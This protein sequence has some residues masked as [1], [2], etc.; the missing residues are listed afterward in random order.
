[1]EYTYNNFFKSLLCYVVYSVRRAD[2]RQGTADWPS[3]VWSRVRI[4]STVALEIVKG[5]GKEPSAWGYNW[6]KLFGGI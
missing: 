6:D 4:T 2:M 1:V 5:D 3:R